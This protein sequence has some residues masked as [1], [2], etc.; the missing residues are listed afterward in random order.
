MST[1]QEQNPDKNSTESMNQATLDESETVAEAIE[2]DDEFEEF[3]PCRWNAKDEDAEDA[4]QWQVCVMLCF[5]V[6]YPKYTPNFSLTNMHLW[7][8]G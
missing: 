4:Q 3:E 1:N 6:Y 8:L 2:E 7:F 5:K